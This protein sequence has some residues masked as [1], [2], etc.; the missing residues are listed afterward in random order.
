MPNVFSGAGQKSV[1]PEKSINPVSKDNE[2]AK[3]AGSSSRDAPSENIREMEED[4]E[5]NYMELQESIK[6]RHQEEREE[7]ETT[8]N[9]M[10][11]NSQN[12]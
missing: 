4:E 5:E 12:K 7:K 3:G 2:T 8:N 9:D 1:R 10:A 11:Q 6:Q